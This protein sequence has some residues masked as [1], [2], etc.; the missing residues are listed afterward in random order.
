MEP[1]IVLRMRFRFLAVVATLGACHI[2]SG[3]DEIEVSDEDGE[4]DSSSSSSNGNGVT[5]STSSSSGGTCPTFNIQVTVN[6]ACRTCVENQCCS[7]LTECDASPDCIDFLNCRDSCFG[8]E[9]CLGDCQSFHPLG[10]GQAFN[11]GYCVNTYCADVC[12]ATF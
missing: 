2:V 8:D 5:S 3:G 10:E 1:A 11:L 7:E 12:P 4:G 9:L 6:P